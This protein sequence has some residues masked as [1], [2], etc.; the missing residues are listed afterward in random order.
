ME[1]IIVPNQQSQSESKQ[2]DKAWI[3]AKADSTLYRMRH[4]RWSAML[5]FAENAAAGSKQGVMSLTF[6]DLF[7]PPGPINSI[8]W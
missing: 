1:F 8:D 4:A 5:A 3:E 6:R 7:Q 2:R